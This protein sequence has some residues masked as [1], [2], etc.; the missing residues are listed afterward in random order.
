MLNLKNAKTFFENGAVNHLHPI[1]KELSAK[2][3][4]LVTGKASFKGLHNYQAI[5]SALSGYSVFHHFEFEVNPNHTD[6]AAGAAKVNAFNPDV[7]LAIGGGSV[8]D[9]AK[10]LSIVPDSKTQI[11]EIIQSGAL[12]DSAPIPLILIPTTAGSG[13]EC[14]QFAVVYI[15]DQKFSLAS[16]SLL[17]NYCILDPEC[18]WSMPPRLT[19]ISGMDALSQ[20]IESF[21]AVASTPQ[22][23]EFSKQSIQLNLSVFKQ[24]VTNPDAASR[25]IMLKASYLAGQ[26]INITKT[27]APHAFSYYLTKKYDIP[28]GQAVGMLLPVFMAYNFVS[29]DPNIN[30]EELHNRISDLCAAL[31]VTDGESAVNKIKDLMVTGGIYL[32]FSDL[33]MTRPS[34]FEEFFDKVNIQRLGN[35]P[36]KVKRDLIDYILQI[37][38]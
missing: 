28:H 8:M 6:I 34:D 16:P 17:P 22:S 38:C 29:N 25:E 2:R 20:A 18:T 15:G 3:V 12:P 24:V 21:W 31:N 5:R 36:V 35:H 11:A 26:A 14:T 27:T 4:F 7:I 23:R 32:R 10:I 1:L 37:S 13:S 30:V 33:K 9:T 19:A